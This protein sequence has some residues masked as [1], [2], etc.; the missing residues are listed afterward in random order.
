MTRGP[1]RQDYVK[2]HDRKKLVM[3]LSVL[4]LAV[5]LPFLMSHL[6]GRQES[7]EPKTTPPRLSKELSNP[8]APPAAKS[9]NTGETTVRKKAAGKTGAPAAQIPPPVQD[10]SLSR[11]DAP[12]SPSTPLPGANAA[13]VAPAPSVPAYKDLRRYYFNVIKDAENGADIVVIDGFS[14]EVRLVANVK[15]KSSCRPFIGDSNESLYYRYYIQAFH[16]DG[17]V[18]GLVMDMVSGVVK[19]FNSIYEGEPVELFGPN[20]TLGSLRYMAR[21]CFNS[22]ALDIYIT[23]MIRGEV[24]W[25]SHPALPESLQLFDEQEE[26]KGMRRYFSWVYYVQ[27]QKN[28]HCL[29]RFTGHIHRLTSSADEGSLRFYETNRLY[30]DLRYSSQV[31]YRFSDVQLITT[32]RFTGECRFM[33][34]PVPDWPMGFS[35]I[36]AR[37]NPFGFR[38]YSMQ[39]GSMLKGLKVLAFDCF[40]NRFTITFFPYGKIPESHRF[41]DDK[42][43]K[44]VD[45]YQVYAFFNDDD[46][47]DVFTIDSYTSQIKIH[48][49]IKNNYK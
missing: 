32:D 49:G 44:G 36:T 35:D 30:G 13:G 47:V 16:Q 11:K 20:R 22:S 34:S 7:E 43:H 1:Y 9:Q 19:S 21:C 24:R 8:P 38:R 42:Q 5:L 28:I 23:D 48:W 29:D 45:R 4:I 3:I 26:N 14:G 41:F 25:V 40:T 31:L 18:A 12:K 39:F 37:A 10:T 27:G 46:S 15:G 33:T 6:V 2:N 17:E